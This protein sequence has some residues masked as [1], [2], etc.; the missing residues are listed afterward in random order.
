MREQLERAHRREI[1]AVNER[2][3]DLRAETQQAINAANQRV[4][5]LRAETQQAINAVNQNILALQAQTQQALQDQQQQIND[6]VAGIQQDKAQA[7]A[8]KQALRE[9]YDDQLSIVSQ[10]NHA[11][12]APRQLQGI[13]NQ[14]NNID[15]LPDTSACAILSQCF[16]SLL[17]L[18][19]DIEQAQAEYEARH[20]ITLRTVEEILARMH[21][22][23]NVPLTDG[24][25]EAVKKENGEV[26]KIELDFWTDGEYGE[27]EKELEAIRDGVV[28]GLNDPSYSSDDLDSSLQRALEINQRQTELVV[29]AIERGNASQ[30]RA[31]MADSIV[32]H[33]KGQS[34]RVLE[35]GYENQDAR[36]AYIIKFDDGTSKIVVIIN[37]EG[38]KTNQVVIGTV[39]T[40]LQEPELIEQGKEIH[41]IIRDELQVRTEGEHCAPFNEEVD[42]A[43]REIYDRNVVSQGIPLSTRKNA[44]ISSAGQKRQA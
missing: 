23:R 32:D 28:N 25:N 36:K 37:P 19:A 27:L 6:I 35:H 8:T 42:R 13:Q 15:A 16:N 43:L 11:K 41:K 4:S 10:K 20:L 31:E 44:N 7:A 22:N 26:A 40:N 14:L 12:Y 29:E 34:F 2:I 21:E 5:N 24:K 9:A 17:T 1:G 18:D 33:F 38:N 3:S 39:E 30:A